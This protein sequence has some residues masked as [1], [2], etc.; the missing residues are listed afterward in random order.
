VYSINKI[1]IKNTDP[2]TA[3]IS[4]VGLAVGPPSSPTGLEIVE[5]GNDTEFIGRDC[6]VQW[7]LNAPFGGAGSLE[8]EL[9]AGIS[10]DNL[11]GLVKDF[12]VEIWN[13][14]E[15]TLYRDYY[16]KDRW[17]IYTYEKNFEDTG[18]SPVGS[19]VIKIYQRNYFNKLSI[20]PARIAVNSDTPATPTG[21]VTTAEEDGVTFTWNETTI[22]DFDYYEYRTKVDS[23]SWSSWGTSYSN[24][25]TRWLNSTEIAAQG[26]GNSTIYIEVR[27]VDLF[28]TVSGVLSGNTTC[29]NF[30]STYI[31]GTTAALGHFSTIQSAVTAAS[32]A[33]GGTVYIKEGS[34]SITTPITLPE[35]DIS[36]L[37]ANRTTTIVNI[38]TTNGFVAPNR[39]KKYLFSD[40]RMSAS[41]T[42]AL[43]TRSM[44]KANQGTPKIYVQQMDL[45]HKDISKGIVLDAS[46]I[47]EG[48]ILNV[49]N[50]LAS[51]GFKILN[52]ASTHKVDFTNN[53][54]SNHYWGVFT[55]ST[56]HSLVAGNI[57][58]KH[59]APAISIN[60]YSN[61]GGG[62]QTISNNTI[63]TTTTATISGAGFCVGL[64]GRGMIEGNTIIS[65]R[66]ATRFSDGR[67]LIIAAKE[68][69][70]V[71]NLV[72]ASFAKD[73]P[74]TDGSYVW[75]IRAA[76]PGCV[77]A[78]NVVKINVAS[79]ADD[80]RNYGILAWNDA[81]RALISDNSINM[82]NSQASDIGIWIGSGSATTHGTGNIIYQAGTGID[83]D[84]GDSS[85]TASVF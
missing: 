1:G 6:K 85:V 31:V 78:G 67:T 62:Y 2:A 81:D 21:L 29:N 5:Q 59:K 51:G 60:Y 9:P 43:S 82:V 23:G 10:I 24:T 19:F 49:N 20:V 58:R 63:I 30:K 37:G 65:D 14:A 54:V 57:F 41:P 12:L 11:S 26:S 28:G 4:I 46:N 33:G 27:I 76:Q 3:N 32:N 71:G 35:A 7:R 61:P 8:P 69:S 79:P 53:N 50:C 40:F 72:T 52:A 64:Y 38:A 25:I 75:G 84:A 77:I 73:P 68:V 34:Y 47:S 36:F 15:T 17:Y 45:I 55:A 39:T 18:G 80:L 22:S 56:D 70:V 42:V 83:D 44:I 16:T 66:T 74:T 48:G 13:S